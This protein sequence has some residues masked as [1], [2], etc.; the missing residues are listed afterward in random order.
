MGANGDNRSAAPNMG[1]VQEVVVDTSAV[2]AELSTGGVR[3]NLRRADSVMLVSILVMTLM[4]CLAMSV[5]LMAVR[6]ITSDEISNLLTLPWS[7][8]LI[9]GL[10]ALRNVQPGVPPLGA[11]GDFFSFLWAE[12]IVA[13][14]AVI[15]IWAWLMRSRP[16]HSEAAR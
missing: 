13:A 15:V 16:S 5:L 1:A 6:A 10:P 8:T 14:S 7:I 3:L 4:M 11:V 2:S 12:I 9:F